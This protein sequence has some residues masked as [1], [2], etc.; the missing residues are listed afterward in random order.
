MEISN[1]EDFRGRVADIINL[2]NEKTTGTKEMISVLSGD[3]NS[4]KEYLVDKS[5]KNIEI[6]EKEESQNN[7]PD[8]SDLLNL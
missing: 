8:F 1:R 3:N 4:I 7:R 5:A 6:K 2:A